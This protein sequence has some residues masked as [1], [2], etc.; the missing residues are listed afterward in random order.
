MS[1]PHDT[2]DLYRYIES[3]QRQLQTPG[4][5][6]FHSL[7]RMKTWF[8][9]NS[10]KF[11]GELEPQYSDIGSPAAHLEKLLSEFEPRTRFDSPLTQATFGPLLAGITLAAERIGIKV[12]RTVHLATSTDVSA[13]PAARP[14]EGPHY[15]FIGLGTSSFCN[16]W[17]KAFTAV[18]R[19]LANDNPLRRSLNRT[20]LRPRS[21]RILRV[22]YWPPDWHSLMAPMVRPWVLGKSSSQPPTFLTAYKSF[23]QWRCSWSATNFHISSQRSE[24]HSS[25]GSLPLKHLSILNIS[26]IT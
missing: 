6:E 8:A 9:E 26:A 22:S 5:E 12:S 15:L 16:Y 4:W 19:A 14:T 7:S 21:K 24:L 11:D 10:I 23:K 25:K 13:S 17:A 3:L 20:R 2:D 1:S 18:I